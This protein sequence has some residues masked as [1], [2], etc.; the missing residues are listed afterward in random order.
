MIFNIGIILSILFLLLVLSMIWPPD[1]P[2]APWWQTDKK[3]ARKMCRLAKVKSGDVVFDLGSGDGTSL[4]VA[5]KEFKARGVG[6]EVDPL[7]IL[8]SKFF[9]RIQNLGNKVVIKKN[10]FF[11]EDIS[12][13]NVVF[14]Y[15]VPKTLYRLKK[16]LLSELKPGTR[17]VTVT[18]EIPGGLGNKTFSN[19]YF[20]TLGMKKSLKVYSKRPL[21][22]YVIPK[23][24]VT[25]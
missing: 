18:Y 6:I 16:K 19:D 12:S 25:S 15:L 3:T 22:L 5:A 11:K 8:L 21:F 13:A 24:K 14:M 10:N 9:V 2:W 7:R 17:I 1:S 4:I 20:K 23:K